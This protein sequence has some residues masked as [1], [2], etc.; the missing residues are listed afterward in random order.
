MIS[1]K[2]LPSDKK[3]INL[4]FIFDLPG[5]IKLPWLFLLIV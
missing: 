2:D 1:R 4:L 3:L 5:T